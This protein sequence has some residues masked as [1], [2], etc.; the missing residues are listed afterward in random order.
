[1]TGKANSMRP[2]PKA[3]KRV[4]EKHDMMRFVIKTNSQSM[5]ISVTTPLAAE[6]FQDKNR[7]VGPLH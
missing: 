4:G 5:H 3:S 1:M 2:R 6:V 7:V